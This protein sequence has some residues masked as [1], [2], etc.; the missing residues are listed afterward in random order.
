[1]PKEKEGFSS[2]VVGTRAINSCSL[3]VRTGLL[4]GPPDSALEKITL[5]NDTNH[6]QTH[7]SYTL[8]TLGF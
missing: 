5:S 1:M 4:V 2:G 8:K 7:K 6:A 3:K